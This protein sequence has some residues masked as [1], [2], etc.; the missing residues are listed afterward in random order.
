MKEL[1]DHKIKFCFNQG[2]DIRLI[3]KE[4]SY[5]IANSRYI[6]DPAFSFDDI[7]IKNIIG[8]KLNIFKT[9]YKRYFHIKIFIYC[10]PK[11]SLKDVLYRVIWAKQHECIPF[12]M[13]DESCWQSPLKDFYT[14]LAAY[15]NQPH[16]IKTKSFQDFMHIRYNIGHP[17]IAQSILLWNNNFP[18]SLSF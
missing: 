14:D 2:L 7:K 6:D 11:H 17:R 4:N 18:N 5:L 13:R 9:Y 1:I 15:C 8:R 16:M 3:D 12:L 10:H